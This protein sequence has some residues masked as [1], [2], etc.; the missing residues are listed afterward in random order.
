MFRVL[1]EFSGN[2]V[3]EIG[4]FVPS[5]NDSN[6]ITVGQMKRIRTFEQANFREFVFLNCDLCPFLSL[7]PSFNLC[8]SIYTVKSMIMQRVTFR[9]LPIFYSFELWSFYLDHS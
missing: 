1:V 7:L 4:I 2:A 8:D 9:S 5:T 6:I 3:S